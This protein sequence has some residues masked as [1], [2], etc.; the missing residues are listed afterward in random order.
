MT[1]QRTIKP[2]RADTDEPIRRRGILAAAVA[3][4]A[5]FVARLSEAPVQATSGAGDQGFLALGSNPWYV[6][7]SPAANAP[8]ISSAPTVIQTSPNFGNFLNTNGASPVVFEVDA[9]PSGGSVDAIYGFTDGSGI[10]VVGSGG[11]GVSGS[12]TFAG[13]SGTSPSTGVSGAGNDTGVSG[14]GAITG[15]FGQSFGGGSA[16]VR[17]VIPN[18]NGGASSIAVYGQNYSTYAG[19]GPGAGGFGVYG[20]S[21]KGH[22]LVGAVASAGAAAVVGATN[23][24]AGAYAAAFYGPVV[25]G[26]DFTVVG[27]KSA[28]VPH[29][30]GSHRRLYC[31][32]SPESWFEDFGTGRLECGRAEIAD[33]SGL[34]RGRRSD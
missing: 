26:G 13:V 30:D 17:G 28:A 8:A 5:G 21:A 33:R 15:V 11:Y 20:L 31:L 19:P 29:P 2:S 7:G 18:T 16:G 12:G 27:A 32:E 14:F 6:A 22:G 24:V 10:G 9:R 1:T 23:G 25:I 4:V 34:C 3:L